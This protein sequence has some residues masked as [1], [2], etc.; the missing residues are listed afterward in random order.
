MT[1]LTNIKLPRIRQSRGSR[2]QSRWVQLVWYLTLRELRSRYKRTAL[3][4]TW[5]LLNPLLTALIL[6]AVFGTIFRVQPPVGDPSGISGFTLYLLA[7]LLPWNMFAACL[8]NSMGVIINNAGLIQKVNFPRTCLVWSTC[9]SAAVTLIIEMA[10]LCLL[11]WAVGNAGFPITVVFVPVVIVIFTTFAAGLGMIFA[12]A[13]VYFRDVAYLMSV[14]LTA[15]FYLTPI[16]YTLALVP[17]AWTIFGRDIPAREIV[18]NNP[19][20]R[21]A[22]A[23]RDLVYDFRLPDG[24]TWGWMVGL[25]IVSL[26]FGLT[27]FRRYERRFAEEL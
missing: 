15:W 5:S 23:F 2:K 4:W 20:T 17:E 9:V 13:N 7:A 8:S 1:E 27:L 16:V 24:P 12:T 11:I 19:V 22:D 3:G 10:V 6:S 21:F 25:A 14:V 18:A 26:A